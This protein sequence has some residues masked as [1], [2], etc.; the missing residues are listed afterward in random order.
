MKHGVFLKATVVATVLVTNAAPLFASE[1]AKEIMTESK[2]TVKEK[3]DDTSI[4][5]LGNIRG[6]VITITN[7]N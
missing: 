7:D 1:G 6:Q 3:L 5:I 2:S 4:K